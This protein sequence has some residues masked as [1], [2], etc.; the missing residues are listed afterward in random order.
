MFLLNLLEVSQEYYLSV[1]LM[2]FVEDIIK[3]HL[4]FLF[5]FWIESTVS[6]K[7][8]VESISYVSQVKSLLLEDNREFT[9]CLFNILSCHSECRGRSFQV[10][11][12]VL[13]RPSVK[14]T[15]PNGKSTA[16]CQSVSRDIKGKEENAVGNKK[17][18]INKE[19]ERRV[20]RKKTGGGVS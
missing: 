10:L 15:A 19:T 12:H 4:A 8:G 16:S 9:A 20:K 18:E 13:S 7:K 17:G 1:L 14:T 11:Y 6:L 5:G 3:Q 2:P